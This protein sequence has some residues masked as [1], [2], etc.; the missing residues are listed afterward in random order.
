MSEEDTKPQE[1][2]TDIHDKDEGDIEKGN[3][4]KDSNSNKEE[5]ISVNENN[6][7]IEDNKENKSDEGGK[8]QE[9]KEE[10]V[11]QEE[12]NKEEVVNDN[13][14]NNENV[15]Q[16]NNQEENIDEI[17]DLQVLRQKIKEK[18]IQISELKEKNEE[19]ENTLEEEKKMHQDDIM[20]YEGK[21]EVERIFHISTNDINEQLKNKIASMKSMSQEL[22]LQFER[23]LELKENFCGMVVSRGGCPE[24]DNFFDELC[25]YKKVLSGGGWKNNIG[26]QRVADKFKFLNSCKF[27]IAFENSSTPGYCTEKLMQAFAARTIPIYFGDP[28]VGQQFNSQAFVNVHDFGSWEDVIKRIIEIDNNDEL[29]LSM[30]QTSALKEGYKD[31]KE[32][33]LDSFFAN[34]VNQD[35]NRAKRRHGQV[36]EFYEKRYKFFT[37]AWYYRGKISKFL[38]YFR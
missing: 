25:K 15:N 31:R 38:K 2:K 7:N 29:Y 4:K 21:L 36:I 19:L 26:G 32:D 1:E 11:N 22:H 27:S 30:M 24:R 5:D 28:H 9:E 18:D 14:N 35:V 6:E 8:N 37:K 13:S 17:T 33:E 3:D 23:E 16:E 20:N 12:I 10:Q 34:I